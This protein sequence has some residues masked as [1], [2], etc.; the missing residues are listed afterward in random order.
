MTPRRTLPKTR[1]GGRSS[2]ARNNA[3]ALAY[4]VEQT[5]GESRDKLPAADVSRIESALAAV[6]SATAGDDAA[7]IAK[8]SE[9]LQRA[10]HAM[11]ETLYKTQAQQGGGTERAAG[12]RGRGRRRIGREI[13]ANRRGGSRTARTT[14]RRDGSRTVPAEEKRN[15]S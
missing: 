5:L 7:A 10:S 6:R 14:H 12:R 8:A 11:A 13:T 15:T 9:E 3:D 1:R 2:E 4:S